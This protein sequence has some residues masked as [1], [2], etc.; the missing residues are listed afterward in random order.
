MEYKIQPYT[1]KRAEEL[2]VIVKPSFNAKKKI[3]VYDLNQNYL[4]SGGAKGYGDF[5]TFLKEKGKAFADERRR[6]YHIR[7]KNES[8]KG[9][10][11]KYLLW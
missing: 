8:I 2:G 6:L 7:H 9:E 4:F 5:S 11:I 10:V 3:D 1:F